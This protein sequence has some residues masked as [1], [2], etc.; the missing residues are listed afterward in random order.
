M[1]GHLLLFHPAF[2]KMKEMCNRG[3]I[4]D[5]QYMYSNRLNWNH[6]INRKRFWSFAPHDVSL[7]QYF[8]E[9]NPQD[10]S[11]T[12][13]DII[14]PGIHDSTITTV[15]YENGFRPYICQLDTSF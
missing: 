10:I 1:V 15:K 6:S 11:S 5:L 12:G 7:F 14:Q 4:G 9:S 13:I 8:A 2:N 3:D